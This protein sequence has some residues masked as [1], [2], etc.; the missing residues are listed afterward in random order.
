MSSE[1][2]RKLR[3]CERDFTLGRAAQL[4]V[5]LSHDE[6]DVTHLEW[7]PV[8]DAVTSEDDESEYEEVKTPSDEVAKSDVMMVDTEDLD[9]EGEDDVHVPEQPDEFS[10][11]FEGETRISLT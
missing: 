9:A 11:L 2:R 10:I 8:P 4:A 5:G 6:D 7:A 3:I 1:V